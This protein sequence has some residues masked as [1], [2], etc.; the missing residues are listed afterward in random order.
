MLVKDA[1]FQGPIFT[2][3]VS[4]VSDA[5]LETNLKKPFSIAKKKKEGREGGREREGGKGILSYNKYFVSTGYLSAMHRILFGV[6]APLCK[7]YETLQSLVLAGAL[8]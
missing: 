7:S 2:N 6:L 3:R 4:G 1:G 8:T 5:R